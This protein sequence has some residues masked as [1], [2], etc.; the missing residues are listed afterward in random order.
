MKKNM[1]VSL[2]PYN[3][4]HANQIEEEDAEELVDNENQHNPNWHK[5]RTSD[6]LL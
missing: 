5:V 1:H 3:Q 4:I 2:E 6:H